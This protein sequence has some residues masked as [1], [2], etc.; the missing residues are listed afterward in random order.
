MSSYQH[1]PSHQPKKYCK[2]ANN[3][4]PEM[5]NYSFF[6]FEVHRLD[7]KGPDP[8]ALCPKGKESPLVQYSRRLETNNDELDLE[9]RGKRL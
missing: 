7:M 5:K 9:I 2:E 4:M 6:F 8:W 1:V 3:Q